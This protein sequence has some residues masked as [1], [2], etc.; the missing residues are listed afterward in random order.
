LREGP[1]A[2]AWRRAAEESG[3]GRPAARRAV[4]AHSLLYATSITLSR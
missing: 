1:A 2:E 3:L 4:T